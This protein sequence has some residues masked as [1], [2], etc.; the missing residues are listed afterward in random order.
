GL[1][2]GM[3]MSRMNATAPADGWGAKLASFVVPPAEGGSHVAF[4]MPELHFD[5]ATD[6]AVH[7][8]LP[9]RSIYT[10][11]TS[12]A[13]PAI[14]QRLSKVEK[15]TF[16]LPLLDTSWA[17]A[18]LVDPRA[19]AAEPSAL[20]SKTVGRLRE[21]DAQFADGASRAVS[22]PS[23]GAGANNFVQ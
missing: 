21:L 17:L 8:Q 11:A 9:E 6:W 1:S 22:K 3:R 12:K 5:G 7:L 23:L 18:N 14:S 16:Q 10:G 2:R 19:V 4:E 15:G 13:E 20:V